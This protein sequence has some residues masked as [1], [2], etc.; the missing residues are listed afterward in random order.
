MNC[1]MHSKQIQ[2]DRLQNAKRTGAET[3]ITTCPKCAIH[4]KCALSG[5]GVV[6]EARIEIEDLG[7]LVAGSLET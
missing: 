1:D 3:L 5:N 7:V 6:D 4:F 2:I